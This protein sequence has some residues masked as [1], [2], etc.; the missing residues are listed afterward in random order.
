MPPL[1]ILYRLNWAKASTVDNEVKLMMKHTPEWVRTPGR[2]ITSP[3]PYLST[4]GP[5]KIPHLNP[6]GYLM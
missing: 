1:C 2:V 6:I 3:V 5:A 4:T